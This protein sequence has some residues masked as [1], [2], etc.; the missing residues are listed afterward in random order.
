MLLRYP[1]Q[2]KMAESQNRTLKLRRYLQWVLH[3]QSVDPDLQAQQNFQFSEENW[4]QD[5]F[6]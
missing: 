4:Q 1:V 5:W 2:E 6:L 3:H